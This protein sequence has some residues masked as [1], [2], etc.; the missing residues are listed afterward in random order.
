MPDEN[1]ENTL[2][3]EQE[4]K[5]L[6]DSYLHSRYYDFDKITFSSVE[7]TAIDGKPA[8]RL[9]GKVTVKSRSMFE[10]ILRDKAANTYKFTVEVNAVNGRIINYVFQ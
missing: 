5:D 9:Y 4:A 10:K 7:N 1:T 6:T 3:S 8:Y 2:V